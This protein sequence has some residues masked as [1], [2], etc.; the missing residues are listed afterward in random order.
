MTRTLRKT[1]QDSGKT[2]GLRAPGILTEKLSPRKPLPDPVPGILPPVTPGSLCQ[3][4]GLLGW[5]PARAQPREPHPRR[6][7]PSGPPPETWHGEHTGTTSPG[8]KQMPWGTW[9]RQRNLSTPRE[10][11]RKEDTPG[12]LTPRVPFQ[13]ALSLRLVDETRERRQVVSESLPR[14]VHHKRCCTVDP[15]GSL[16]LRHRAGGLT[17]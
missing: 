3:T 7:Q 2:P 9:R 10:E 12:S 6:A 15:P 1:L 4:Q 14:S 5:S 16:C 17:L 11:Q 8:I 13:G